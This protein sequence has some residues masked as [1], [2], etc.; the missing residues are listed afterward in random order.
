MNQDRHYCTDCV[1]LIGVVTHEKMASYRITLNTLEAEKTSPHLL[2]LGE[3]KMTKLSSPNQQ[4]IFQF[5]LESKERVHIT[6]TVIS[7]KVA[8]SL[9]LEE[10]TENA[11]HT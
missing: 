11:I 7:G 9:G 1:Y 2:K 8:I 6:P 5:M 4:K 10:S 3:V